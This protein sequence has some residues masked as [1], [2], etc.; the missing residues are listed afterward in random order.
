MRSKFWAFHE[1]VIIECPLNIILLSI[2]SR[3]KTKLVKIITTQKDR[4][5]FKASKVSNNYEVIIWRKK[6]M[7]RFSAGFRSKAT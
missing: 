6:Y 7:N 5:N 2:F 3:L 4:R 1:H